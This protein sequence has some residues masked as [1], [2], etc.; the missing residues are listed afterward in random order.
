MCI[1]SNRY[2]FYC[3]IDLVAKII[4]SEGTFLRTVLHSACAREDLRGRS[5]DSH[6]SDIQSIEL[7]LDCVQEEAVVAENNNLSTRSRTE[8]A[9]RL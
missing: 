1:N 3:S 6:V 9:S 8:Q 7:F 5:V 2:V 4:S